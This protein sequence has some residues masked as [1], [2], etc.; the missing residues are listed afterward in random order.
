M[1]PP[2]PALGLRPPSRAPC[3]FLYGL[4]A[5]IINRP[6]RKSSLQSTLPLSPGILPLSQLLKPPSSLLKLL[7][8]PTPLGHLLNTMSLSLCHNLFLTRRP[9]KQRP[10]ALLESRPNQG[11]MFRCA[12]PPC[13][14]CLTRLTR[15]LGRR[16]TLSQLATVLQTTFNPNSVL[17]LLTP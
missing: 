6:G 5:N 15:C 14:R 17:L 3:H 1:R 8:R 4:H 11:Q 2:L 7:C 12:C 9:T 10:W 16:L 13:T